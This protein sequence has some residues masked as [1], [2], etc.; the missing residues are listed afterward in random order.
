MAREVYENKMTLVKLKK[1]L[2][3]VY[4]EYENMMDSE[5][6]T[7]SLV[8]ISKYFEDADIKKAV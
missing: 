7:V 8:T 5:N 4:N 2:I 6:E 1:L 3:E